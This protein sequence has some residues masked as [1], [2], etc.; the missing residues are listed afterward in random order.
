M[1]RH[2][3]AGVDTDPSVSD[4]ALL[5]QVR[6]GSS[7]AYAILWER[8]RG[9]AMAFASSFR[10]IAP[11]EDLVAEAYTRIL[12][13]VRNDK[14]PS[15]AFRAYLIAT[16]RNVA[17]SWGRSGRREQVVEDLDLLEGS[18]SAETE[19]LRALDSSITSRAFRMLLPRWQEVLWYS[20]IEQLP[21][22]EIAVLLG[23]TP[24]AV[25]QLIFRA[26]EAL[27][28]AWIQAHLETKG[29]DGEHRAVVEMLGAHVRGSL[30]RRDE[31]TVQRHLEGCARC[32][33]IA[34]EADNIGARLAF[35]ILPVVAGVAGAAH[36]L[37]AI[38][39]GHPAAPH[40]AADAGGVDGS[41]FGAHGQSTVTAVDG[42][43]T[44]VAGGVFGTWTAPIGMAA[45]VAVVAAAIAG[46][47]SVVNSWSPPA[48]VST[49]AASPPAPLRDDPPAPASAPTPTPTPTSPT[50]D[51]TAPPV[52]DSV[53]DS[54][55]PPPPAPVVD[56]APADQSP[57][58]A[59]IELRVL[60]PADQALL[61]TPDVRL[62]AFA[63]G[64]HRI[65]I[66]VDGHDYSVVDAS[67]GQIDTNVGP[68]A[69]GPH[70]VTLSSADDAAASARAAIHF[71]VDTIAAAPAITLDQDPEQR[72]LPGISVTAEPGAQL[73]VGI[74][75][76]TSVIHVG[77]SGVWTGAAHGVQGGDHLVTA[78]Q[79]D[80]AGNVS[81]LAAA[82][83][84]LRAP[85]L[86][87]SRDGDGHLH[88][89]F[90][91]DAGSRVEVFVDGLSQGIYESPE[92]GHYF[93][94]EEE[95][96][97]SAMVI[98]I[99]YADPHNHD[100]R[101]AMVIARVPDPAPPPHPASAQG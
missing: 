89:T 58:P 2:E 50:L 30:S 55:V 71:D 7:R 70:T 33:I 76:K 16:V 62:R 27:R 48:I 44:K 22:A 39:A 24:N 41:A 93:L 81:P 31:R 6:A 75:G 26:K 23:M 1:G 46:G 18:E 61:A 17:I 91:A 99:R 54:A 20:E 11:A 73:E 95:P 19:A 40:A 57:S 29:L 32:L 21:R 28:A 43:S 13:A 83:F 12:A 25:S 36:Y 9:S 35:I 3:E 63:S 96:W 92:S 94:S 82:S 64:I 14:G 88:A 68:L 4:G 65:R 42:T 66:T 98:A 8:H 78:A 10:N 84:T 85:T 45:S 74:D 101:G 52:T 56:A 59:P 80:P 34:A 100:R 37:A 87:L 5:E 86:H 51:P 60:E 47:V 97:C 38:G 79:T 72:Y 69:D 15:G 67:S 49:V 90:D 53:L 77:N